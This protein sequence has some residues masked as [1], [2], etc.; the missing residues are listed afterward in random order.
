LELGED[1]HHLSVGCDGF[2]GQLIL[3][4]GEGEAD[5]FA[6]AFSSPQVIGTFVDPVAGD[7]SSQRAADDG[8]LSDPA[9]LG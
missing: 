6:L 1:F 9:R 2:F 8:P 7:A 5:G 3:G 4:S